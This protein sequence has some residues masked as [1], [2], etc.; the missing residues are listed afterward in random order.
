MRKVLEIPFAK[1]LEITDYNVLD[2]FW[3]KSRYKQI[4][5]D[6]LL[7]FK[8][9]ELNWNENT[10]ELNHLNISCPKTS[11]SNTVYHIS[12][13]ISNERKRFLR[14]DKS[15]SPVQHICKT[16]LII[17]LVPPLLYRCWEIPLD[18][19]TALLQQQDK[20]SPLWPAQSGTG[21]GLWS[22]KCNGA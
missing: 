21:T 14:K 1:I 13:Q 17:L 22:A 5:I 11:L 9:V 4:E 12:G 19:P 3:Y 10:V 8:P 18:G 16:V 20:A 7:D 15:N 2:W 6:I